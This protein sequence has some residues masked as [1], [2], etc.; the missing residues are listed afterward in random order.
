[1][2]VF[3]SSVRRGPGG[4]RDALPGLLLA[5]GHQ[6]LRF[7]D[8]T[9]QSVPS[10]EACLRGIEAADAYILLLGSY[11]GARFLET[12]LSATHEEY[13]AAQTKGIPRL[14][15]R[16]DGVGLDPE[17]EAFAAEVETY[18]T[19]VF[20]DRFTDVVD[21]QAKVAAALR[22]LPARSAMLE[23]ISLPH[24]VAIEWR[25]EW[26]QPRQAHTT[27][28]TVLDAH[29]VQVSGPHLTA[30]QM[31]GF[32]DQLATRLRTISAVPGSVAIDARLQWSR[33]LGMSEP[34]RPP[35]RMGRGAPCS[36]SWRA[37]RR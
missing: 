19:G 7:E 34:T 16:K 20:R 35:R 10:R 15:F 9:A 13:V 36:A 8:F 28:G 22:A 2:R 18:G 26:A 29:A 3:I 25:S 12:G 32:G 14:V 24:P 5:L 30:R 21:I 31:R 11:Y 4:E 33:G 37:H 1:V 17:Q 6:P 27:A 23:W